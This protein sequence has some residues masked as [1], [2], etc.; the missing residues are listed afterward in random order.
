[1]GADRVDV[2]VLIVITWISALY[3]PAEVDA[4]PRGSLKGYSFS[5][6]PLS[7][8]CT[9]GSQSCASAHDKVS[10]DVPSLLLTIDSLSL[11]V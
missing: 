7:A 4:G 9:S 10:E 6:L 2:V 11:L 3:N 5:M 1:M 8:R